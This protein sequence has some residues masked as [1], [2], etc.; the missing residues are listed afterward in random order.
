MRLRE[1]L[2][3]ELAN[4]MTFRIQTFVGK[5]AVTFSVSGRLDE[6]GIAEL[7]RLF[8]QHAD[9]HQIDLD[10]NEVG[11]VERDA[12]RA[13]AGFESSGIRLINSPMYVRNW[14]SAGKRKGESV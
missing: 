9:G 1:R 5:A 4:A 3:F 10:L 11:L 2:A 8:D 13:L 7:R 14:M 12:I 6:E